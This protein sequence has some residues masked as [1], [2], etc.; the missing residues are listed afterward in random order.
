MAWT[1]PLR[2]LTD[3]E[4]EEIRQGVAQGI[5]GPILDKWVRQLLA[6][7]DERVRLQHQDGVRTPGPESI[8][9]R[10]RRGRPMR[11]Q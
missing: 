9:L 3:Q 10:Y 6:D 1:E 2:L 8:W 4:V 7:R 11:D 5:R